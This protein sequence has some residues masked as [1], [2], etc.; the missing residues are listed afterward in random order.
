MKPATLEGGAVVQVP[1]FIETGERIRIDTK[2]MKYVS[3]SEKQ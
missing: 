2:E 3:R 1:M